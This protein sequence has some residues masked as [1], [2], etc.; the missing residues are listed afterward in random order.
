MR[1]G[2]RPEVE[3]SPRVYLGYCERHAFKSLGDFNAGARQAARPPVA[4]L[5][6]R[7]DAAVRTEP[8]SWRQRL[9]HTGVGRERIE[10]A[11]GCTRSTL[12]HV[13]DGAYGPKIDTQ[14]V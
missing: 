12:G 7:H 3:Q 6:L 11:K 8:P 10:L 5:R 1:D 14:H 4:Q 9:R 2:A 13:D